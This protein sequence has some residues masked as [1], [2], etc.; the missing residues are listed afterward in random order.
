MPVNWPEM[1]NCPLPCQTG[2]DKLSRQCSSAGQTR[3]T[4]GNSIIPRLH[5]NQ[6][7]LFR[8]IITMAQLALLVVNHW[9]KFW[10]D[11]G[12]LVWLL[13]GA[14]LV[15]QGLMQWQV[16]HWHRSRILLL[17]DLLA[18]AVFFVFLGGVSNPLI[19]CL[20]L[21]VVLSALS[22]SSGFTW[23]LTGLSNA[24]YGWLWWMAAHQPV[25]GHHSA[26]MA[27]H[28][29]GMWLGFI[30]ISGLL[31]WVTTTLMN[32]IHAKNRALLAM[33][34]QR[35]ADESLIRMATLA[36]SLAHELGTPL[37]SIRLLT[38]EIKQHDATR[39]VRQ[40]L[41]LLDSQVSRCKSV[42]ERL[43]ELADKRTGVTTREVVVTEFLEQLAD[44]VCGDRMSWHIDHQAAQ[45]LTIEVDDLLELAIT[46]VLNNSVAAGGKTLHMTV[47]GTATDLCI[48]F[49]DDG[50]GEAYENP[51][52]LGMGLKLT[53][54][55]LGNLGGSMTFEASGQG[56][57]TTMTL[58]VNHG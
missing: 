57:C 25:T 6:L 3:Y 15:I 46:N 47:R 30:A 32:R 40:D 34:K 10:P 17:V 33:E 56:A 18:W 2:C 38:E 19:W 49:T 8:L 4:G 1:E 7:F 13:C 24:V 9:L 21:P 35:Q 22:Q 26:M 20:L 31:S 29:T 5:M 16:A 51:E 27:E 41:E 42:L 45:T 43:T 37:A 23:L 48:V 39:P 44:R 52:G 55:I 54:R 53:A 28:L 14:Y 58:P 36:T 12:P 50:G 11:V